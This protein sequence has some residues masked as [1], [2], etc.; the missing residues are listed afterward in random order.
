MCLQ[1]LVETV[2]VRVL[3]KFMFCNSWTYMRQG[4]LGRCVEIPKES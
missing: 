2:L 4:G 3:S 1:Y